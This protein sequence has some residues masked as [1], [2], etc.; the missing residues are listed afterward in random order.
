[1]TLETWL[2]TLPGHAAPN[3]R[4]PLIHTLHLADL[5]PLSGVWAGRDRCPCPLYPEDSPP[6]LHAATK[7]ATPFRLNLHVGDVGHTLVFGPTGAGKSTLLSTIAAQF[8][9][10]E[11]AT[12]Y[13]FDKGRSMMALAL[14]C[15]GRHHDI[16]GE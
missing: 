6:L 3:I 11:G 8:R 5:L 16:G 7:G 14:A 4:R 12:I 9:R 15:G 10:Y 2:G 1:N 13:S